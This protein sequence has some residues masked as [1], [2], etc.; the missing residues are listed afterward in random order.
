MGALVYLFPCFV[1]IASSPERAGNARNKTCLRFCDWLSPG[2]GLRHEQEPRKLSHFM[3]WRF[4]SVNGICLWEA[5]GASLH[6]HVHSLKAAILED[7]VLKDMTIDKRAMSVLR[8]IDNLA[9]NL[10]N[11]PISNRIVSLRCHWQ[12]ITVAVLPKFSG[13]DQQATRKLTTAPSSW[14]V[15]LNL[16]QILCM[17]SMQFNQSL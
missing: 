17:L 4:G 16:T 3:A 13:T 9:H 15:N 1:T 11:L 10:A 8:V 2:M 12:G 7:C 6:I 5:S 14:S